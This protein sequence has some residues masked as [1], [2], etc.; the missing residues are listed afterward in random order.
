MATDW[1]APHY[2]H[3]ESRNAAGIVVVVDVCAWLHSD[4][5]VWW[6]LLDIMD[7]LG[8]VPASQCVSKWV[9]MRRSVLEAALVAAGFTWA[10][11]FKPSL[12]SLAATSRTTDAEN[13]DSGLAHEQPCVSTMG[14]VMLLLFLHT[15]GH[16]HSHRLWALDVLLCWLSKAARPDIVERCCL[17]ECSPSD[18]ARCHMSEGGALC[19]H[20]APVMASLT[21]DGGTPQ[22][23]IAGFLVGLADCTAHCRAS[24]ALLHSALVALCGYIRDGLQQSAWTRDPLRAARLGDCEKGK[25]RRH[26]EAFKEAVV[27]RSVKERRAC[28]EGAYMRSHGEAASGLASQWTDQAM[29]RYQSSCWLGASN[30]QLASI[31]LDASRLGNLAQ[32]V[33]CFAAWVEAPRQCFGCWLPPQAL[34]CGGHIFRTAVAGSP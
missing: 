5:V 26:D 10:Q 6:C 20:A 27:D 3:A 8:V 12:R 4:G 33:V 13:L 21:A 28:S 1:P 31:A 18:I 29:L 30:L 11:A 24:R 32:D 34:V 23:R 22:E 25:R 2:I 14:L 7:A 19:A 9:K 15:R 17:A 16:Q